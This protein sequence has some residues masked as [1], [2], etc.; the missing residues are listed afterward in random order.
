MAPAP[1]HSGAGHAGGQSGGR[2]ASYHAATVGALYW[3][4]RL[5]RAA[6]S[7]ASSGYACAGPS[8]AGVMSD[9]Q[10]QQPRPAG[11]GM[12]PLMASHEEAGAMGGLGRDGLNLCEGA[13]E[14]TAAPAKTAR[15]SA[16]PPGGPEPEVSVSRA[17]QPMGMVVRCRRRP[18]IC[19]IIVQN[20]RR[21]GSGRLAQSR[22]GGQSRRARAAVWTVRAGHHQ[23]W[24][25]PV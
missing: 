20:N 1:N 7:T 25:S 13:G 6:P 23:A 15:P 19:I 9:G 10:E 24:R 8:R 2:L 5:A 17:A 4:V 22:G 18:L 14:G 12:T 21:A 16:L 3:L 11:P